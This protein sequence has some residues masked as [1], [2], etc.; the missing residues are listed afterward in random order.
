MFI[1]M[2]VCENGGGGCDSQRRDEM[3]S[4]PDRFGK[5]ELRSGLSTS[6]HYKAK[7][8]YIRALTPISCPTFDENLQ[9]NPSRFTFFFFFFEFEGSKPR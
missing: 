2:F 8:S 1:D 9:P 3:V 5:A 4:V 7:P 6:M